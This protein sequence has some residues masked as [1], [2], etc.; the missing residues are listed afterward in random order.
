MFHL[1]NAK[2]AIRMLDEQVGTPTTAHM[3]QTTNQGIVYC[4]K[5]LAEAIT[6]IEKR[7]QNIELD[8]D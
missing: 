4:L 5:E 1:D 3:P 6:S 7:V 2:R 8:P